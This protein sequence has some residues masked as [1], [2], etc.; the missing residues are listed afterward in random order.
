M[1]YDDELLALGLSKNEAKAYVA[2]CKSGALNIRSL[3]LE[4]GTHRVLL[5]DILD[6]LINR[7]LARVLIKGGVKYFEPTNPEQLRE[8]VKE[9]EAK[10]N[11][12]LA[13][14]LSK[15]KPIFNSTPVPGIRFFT[16]VNGIKAA[17]LEEINELGA[18]SEILMFHTINIKRLLNW[19]PA[20]YHKLRL[21]NKIKI[22]AISDASEGN[23][24][25]NQE[26]RKL[27]LVETRVTEEKVS[28]PMCYHVYNNKVLIFSF[29][30]ENLFA[31]R[32]E[33]CN[34][35]NGFEENFRLLWN[36]YR[37]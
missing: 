5:Y 36:K 31:I 14:I 20:Y 16:G 33:D 4:T 27:G 29:A 13:A 1:S 6:K 22:K 23:L 24:K 30:K 17:L 2:L 11:Q 32:I 19:F 25:R 15:L 35:A 10:M 18:N 9:K 8:I 34:I 21:E 37:T 28:H 12:A 26:L 7:G 3:A